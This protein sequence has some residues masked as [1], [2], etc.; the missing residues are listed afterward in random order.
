[1]EPTAAPTLPPPAP[2]A[3][4]LRPCASA[5]TVLCNPYRRGL[6]SGDLGAVSTVRCASESGAVG[7]ETLRKL[8]HTAWEV[9]AR[10]PGDARNEALDYHR[11]LVA[12]SRVALLHLPKPAGAGRV[13]AVLED[14]AAPAVYDVHIATKLL[15]GYADGAATSA[16]GLAN[17]AM[18][19]EAARVASA[20]A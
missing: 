9:V 14:G 13:L 16:A 8:A 4:P 3:A 18:G 15:E 20:A 19:L 6:R 7:Y 5:T 12:W 2:V 10:W 1:M 17:V 11:L